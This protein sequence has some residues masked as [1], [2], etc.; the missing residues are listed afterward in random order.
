MG[1]YGSPKRS[2]TPADLKNDGQDLIEYALLSAFIG[3]AGVA[4]FNGMG[5]TMQTAIRHWADE[6]RSAAVDMPDPD[7]PEF[8]CMPIGLV[9]VVVLAVGVVACVTDVRS[10]KIPNMLTF[11]AA[12]CGLL[13]HVDGARVCM[14]W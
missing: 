4:V 3:L 8:S 2:A 14:A 1:N 6:R 7:A 5:A 12:A 9:P 10:R 13:F 11:G